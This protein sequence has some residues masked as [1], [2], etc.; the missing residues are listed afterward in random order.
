MACVKRRGYLGGFSASWAPLED[1]IR[2]R[3]CQPCRQELG[4]FG[5]KSTDDDAI[6]PIIASITTHVTPFLHVSRNLHRLCT[7]HALS[8]A[9]A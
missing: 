5:N 7:Q 6:E 4:R 2:N 3:N 1:S 9:C 8:R